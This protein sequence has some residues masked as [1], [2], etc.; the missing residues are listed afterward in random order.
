MRSES[1]RQPLHLCPQ[2]FTSALPATMLMLKIGWAPGTA[3][4]NEHMQEN[5]QCKWEIANSL[6]V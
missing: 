3:L 1:G 4:S 2:N 5:C 6:T